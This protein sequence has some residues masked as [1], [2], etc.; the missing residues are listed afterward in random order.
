MTAGSADHPSAR[1]RWNIVANYGGKLWSIASVYLFVPIYIRLLGVGAYGLVAFYSVAL[2]IL[3]IADA[4]LSSAF[5]R[6]AARASDRGRLAQLL[7]STEWA[8]LAIVGVAGAIMA[9]C[10][11]AV[12]GHWLKPGAGVDTELA[13][14]CIRLMPLALV[15]QIVIAL[16]F[17]GLMGVQRQVA[18]NAYTTLFSLVRSGLVVLP[19]WLVPDVRV[20]FLW[21]AASSWVF[22]FVIRGSLRHDLGVSRLG[23]GRFSWPSLQ[24][25]MRY[26][27]GM[28]AMSVIAGVNN[29]LDR[30]V[31][32]SMRPLEEFAWY[33]LAATLA[34][35]P[36]IVTTPIATALLPRFTELVEA[37]ARRPLR[38]LYE[39]NSYL[40][41][42]VAA[43]AACALF[44]FAGD[45]AAV[46]ITRREVPATF[47]PVIQVLSVGGLFLA[48]QLAPFQLSLA[49]G[50]N[51]TNVTLG[52]WVLLATVPLQVVLTSRL[53]LLGAGVPWLL[54]NLLAFVYLGVRLNGRFNPGRVRL[55]F[56]CHCLPPVAVALP[57]LALARFV[58]DGAGARGLAA[59]LVALLFAGLSF[60]A[61]YAIRPILM[62]RFNHD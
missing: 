19:I 36:T 17:G 43:A 29:Q 58:A 7:A 16:Y 26:A 61:S 21:Q 56:F 57:M 34:Q 13:T 32:S 10:A 14:Q 4:G 18:A 41:A 24:P 23:L 3:Y 49:N 33:T 40:I 60:A 1:L 37:G 25:V 30:L 6:E 39:S 11:P 2:A 50:H 5:A 47:A 35:I 59:C 53:G 28:F 62:R 38:D 12:A 54:L 51:R 55:W 15:P 46:W 22:L 44:F 42:A 8:L 45:V 20:F 31:V 52:A 48:L 27:A 9:A